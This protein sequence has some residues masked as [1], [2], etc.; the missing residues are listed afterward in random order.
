MSKVALVTGG[1]SG[2]GLCAA[3]ELYA[4]GCRVYEIS[5]RD[6]KTLGVTHVQADVSDEEQVCRAVRFVYEK[7][8]RLDILV[9]NAGFG[10]SGI[11][12]F[13]ANADAVS[14]LD[15][16]LFGTVN[17]T[18]AVVPLMRDAGAGRIVNVSSFAALT[19]IPFQSWYSV[20]KAAVNAY[21]MAIACELSPF[22]ISVC[23]VMPGDTKTAFTSA[24][25]KNSA[26]DNIYSGRE[27]RSV[28]KMEQDETNG[29]SPECAA[30]F[31]SRIAIKKRVKPYYV[32]GV[33][34]KFLA[35]LVRLLP[36]NAVKRIVGLMYAK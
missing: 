27:S 21:T 15:V 34:Y 25:K 30:R 36:A 22:G 1:S 31:I 3:Q 6:T 13:T 19:P 12:E 32:I 20:S 18:K 35:L 28:S 10:I 7:E 23:A 17:A 11:A 9:N 16:N 2:I 29:M 24:R 33:K 14:L 5:R 8:G 4:S 26:G